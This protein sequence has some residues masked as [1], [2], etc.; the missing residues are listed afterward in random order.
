MSTSMERP[1]LMVV[2]DLNER[3]ER[4]I[5]SVMTALQKQRSIFLSNSWTCPYSFQCTSMMLGG[6]EKQMS[7]QG[8][9]PM[10]TAPFIGFGYRDLVDKIRAF[11]PPKWYD[12]GCRQNSYSIQAH[13]CGPSA[14]GYEHLKLSLGSAANLNI[15]DYSSEWPAGN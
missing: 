7:A 1:N 2:D 5:Q 14:N 4:A 15:H 3:R 13:Y 9:S 6:L 11:S 8:L 12:E 10:P